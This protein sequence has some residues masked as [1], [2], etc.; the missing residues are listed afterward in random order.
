MKIMKTNADWIVFIQM[1]N[2][3]LTEEL[4]KT[5]FAEKLRKQTKLA[6]KSIESYQ[7]QLEVLRIDHCSE[8]EKKNIIKDAQN[9]YVFTK[10][11]LKAFNT[12][13]KKL[14]AEPCE[15]KFILTEED[16]LSTKLP[17]AITEYY[18]EFLNPKT[19]D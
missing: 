3:V 4:S 6:G 13:N 19:E 8:D 15:C 5:K 1:T 14:L 10:E 17:E 9:N 16:I 12:A 7:D 11:N 2:Q 18:L